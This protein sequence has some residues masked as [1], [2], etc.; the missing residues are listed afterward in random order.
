MAQT[1]PPSARRIA[2]L[3]R[4]GPHGSI[5]A[6][7]GLEVVLMG[8]AFEQPVCLVF[9]DDGVFALCRGQDTRT[10]GVKDFARAYPALV[11]YELERV[12]VERESMRARGLSPEDL[13]LEV[14]VL[15]GAGI[16]ELLDSAHV[17]LSF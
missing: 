15:D 5:H 17:V 9:V 11:D 3:N 16:S 10:L 8:A 7:E 6:L 4:R 12:V 2:F 13:L 1:P 14:E